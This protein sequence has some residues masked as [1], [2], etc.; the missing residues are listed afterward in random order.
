[1]APPLRSGPEEALL[2]LLRPRAALAG[3]GEGSTEGTAGAPLPSSVL[4]PPTSSPEPSSTTTG[5]VVEDVVG[6]GVPADDA[7]ASEVGAGV[8][9]AECEAAAERDGVGVRVRVHVGF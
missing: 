7:E 4:V 5:I 8:G 6:T 1:M 3:E 9:A 2:S